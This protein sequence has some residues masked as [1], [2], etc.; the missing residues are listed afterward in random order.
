MAYANDQWGAI[1]RFLQPYGY[2]NSLQNAPQQGQQQPQQQLLM[3]DQAQLQPLR[4]DGRTT[5]ITQQKIGEMFGSKSATPISDFLRK[6]M[7][8]FMGAKI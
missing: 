4:S 3:P 8:A 1:Q 5:E 7:M 2:I 6:N